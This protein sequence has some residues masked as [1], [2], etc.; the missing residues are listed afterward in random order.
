MDRHIEHCLNSIK[1]IEEL[2]SRNKACRLP[3]VGIFDVLPPLR[4]SPYQPKP[5]SKRL[6]RG[7]NGAARSVTM[8][9]LGLLLITL[10][11]WLAIKMEDEFLV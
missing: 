4:T 5:K 9:A 1:M 2:V 3:N 8:T 6:K 11:V 7:K 10:A